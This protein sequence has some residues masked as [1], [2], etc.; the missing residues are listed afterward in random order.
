MASAWMGVGRVKPSSLMPCLRL[1]WSA[2]ALNGNRCPCEDGTARPRVGRATDHV[3]RPQ[4]GSYQRTT[5]PF[6]NAFVFVSVKSLR[7][8]RVAKS[9]R[10]F[11]STT[12][13]T[14]S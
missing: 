7:L 3:S 10:P 13:I 8:L 2:S 4:A 6:L 14:T 11:P 5:L 1:G 12:G 9:V